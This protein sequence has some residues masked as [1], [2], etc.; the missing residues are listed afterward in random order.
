[1]TRP[2]H[3]NVRMTDE[4]WLALIELVDV[5]PGVS[6]KTAAIHRAVIEAR[7]RSRFM[8]RHLIS[9]SDAYKVLKFERAKDYADN[10]RD[11]Q[12]RMP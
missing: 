10:L 3:I 2:K 1:M 7:D 11:V 12:E 4:I 5:M 6:N 8:R 9:G